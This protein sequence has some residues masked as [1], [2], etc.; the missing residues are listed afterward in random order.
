MAVWVAGGLAT[1]VRLSTTVTLRC[2]GPDRRTVSGRELPR[3]RVAS[4][5]RIDPSRVPAASAP[6]ASQRRD[7]LDHRR[8]RHDC[9]RL[10][11]RQ[12]RRSDNRVQGSPR[13]RDL[14]LVQLSRRDRN[15]DRLQRRAE[16]PVH[17]RGPP[18]R[19]GTPHWTDLGSRLCA[20]PGV[21]SSLRQAS[22]PLVLDQRGGTRQRARAASPFRSEFGSQPSIAWPSAIRPSKARAT[23][24]PTST[25]PLSEERSPA[26]CRRIPAH[27]CPRSGGAVDSG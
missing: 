8:P 4:R 5:N 7:L 20:S 25:P 18:R 14:R 12:P 23:H 10:R 1:G 19:P 2:A 22:R 6:V 21:S 9:E 11:R 26:A 13:R 16:T 24:A 27:P 17:R 3:S 15:R